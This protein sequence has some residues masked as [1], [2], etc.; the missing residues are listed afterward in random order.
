MCC[1]KVILLSAG[2]SL[3]A[4][5]LSNYKMTTLGLKRA[6]KLFLE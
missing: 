1:I 4:H 3:D 5:S 6:K 2:E